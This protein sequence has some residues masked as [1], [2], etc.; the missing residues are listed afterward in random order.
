MQA[1]AFF[2]HVQAELARALASHPNPHTNA[3]ARD[4][5]ELYT[6]RVLDLL[7][8]AHAGNNPQL[9]SWRFVQVA[10]LCLRLSMEL[11]LPEPKHDERP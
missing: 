4:V 8:E 7:P 2:D 3:T 9:L 11:V 10:G 6:K 1:S 5:F